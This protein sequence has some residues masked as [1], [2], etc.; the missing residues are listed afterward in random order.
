MKRIYTRIIII[1]AGVAVLSSCKKYLDVQPEDKVLEGQMFSTERGINTVLNGLY[2]NLSKNNL[3]G[4]NLTLSTVDILAQR[5]NVPSTH[6][7]YKSATYAYADK[8]IITKIDEMWSGAY[9]LI[10]NAN[11]FAE[12]LEKYKGILSGKTDSIYRGEAIGMRALLHFDMLRLFGPRYSTADS[13][14]TAIPYYTR[15]GSTIEPLLPANSVLD[16]IQADLVKAE[17]LLKADPIIVNG[18]MPNVLNNGTDFLR[19]RN[20]RINYYAIKA[21]QARVSLYRGNKVPALTAAKEVIQNISKFPWVT[22][23]NAL[24]EKANPDRVFT[25]EMILGTQS[26]QLYNN[27]LNNF[28]PDLAET[29]ILAPLAARLATVFESNENDYRYNLNWAVPSNGGKTYRTFYKYADVIDKTKTFR[30]S[31]PLIK[32][33]E[34]YYIAAE[35]ETDLNQ[36]FANINTV[37]N[38]RGLTSLPVTTSATLNTELQKEYQKE[39]FGEG[40]LFYYYKR[41]NITSIPNGSATSGNITMTANTFVLPLPLSETQ[42]RP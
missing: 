11:S 16:R 6:D 4:D 41:R 38:N 35:C 34:V 33:S 30:F 32:I 5:Y 20:Y 1:L 27:Y 28:T 37:R 23:T 39:F 8:P 13:I 22:V 7:L 15:S 29:K 36:A 18:V 10:L 40:Q 42:T 12:N 19:N 31:V 25:T 14:K 26:T 21:L 24:S 17:Q 3:Y 9:S 2:I